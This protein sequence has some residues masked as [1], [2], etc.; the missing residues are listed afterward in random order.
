[1]IQENDSKSLVNQRK[2]GGRYN[3]ITKNICW[4]WVLKMGISW[5]ETVKQSIIRQITLNWNKRNKKI[6]M[7]MDI[8]ISSKLEKHLMDL[9]VIMTTPKDKIWE[10]NNINNKLG[11]VG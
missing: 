4:V 5:F 9:M 3:S 6:V 1:M 8:Q 2:I 10:L 11:L 7:V